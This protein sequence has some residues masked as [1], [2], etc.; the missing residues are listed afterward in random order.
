VPTLANLLLHMTVDRAAYTQQMRAAKQD[1]DDF[2]VGVTKSM[3]QAAAATESA[4]TRMSRAQRAQM[5]A[6]QAAVN[7]SG[8][9]NPSFAAAENAHNSAL[10]A[11]AALKQTQANVTATTTAVNGMNKS[12]GTTQY[13]IASFAVLGF[14]SFLTQSAHAAVD[15]QQSMLLL[16]TQ[17]RASTAEVRNMT[18]AVMQLAPALRTGPEELSKSLYHIESVGYRGSRALDIL[19]ISAQGARLGMSDIEDT[20]NA[21]VAAT[22]SGIEGID[23]M[24]EAMGTLD[25][26]VGTGNM[27]MEELVKSLRSGILST[28]KQ[29]GISLQDLTAALATMTDQGVPAAEAATRLRISIALLAAPTQTAARQLSRIGLT[30]TQIAEEMAGPRGLI[31]ALQLLRDHLTKSGLSAEQQSQLLVRAFGGG[32]TSS[33]I[34]LLINSL[35][36]MQQKLDVINTTATKFPELVQAQ[37]ETAAARFQELSAIVEVL[38]IQFGNV[39]LPVL[40]VVAN[41]IGMI[42]SQTGIMIP[43]LTTLTVI[44]VALATK[45]LVIF[46]AN[47]LKAG[48]AMVITATEAIANATGF[49]AMATASGAATISVSGLAAA[50]TALLAVLGP[51]A[52]A[53]AA[54]GAAYAIVSGNLD[55]QTQSLTDSTTKFANDQSRSIQELQTARDNIQKYLNELNKKDI[56]GGGFKLFGVWDV[57]GTEKKIQAQI[58]ILD[59]AIQNREAMLNGM[60]AAVGDQADEVLDQTKT[61]VELF[62]TS[63]EGVKDAAGAAGGAAMVEMAKEIRAHQNAPLDALTELHD[64]VRNQLTPTAEIA[65]L[66]GMLTAQDLVEG[67][68]SQDPAVYAQAVATQK[69]ITERLDELTNGAY[70]AGQNTT[71]NLAKGLS[72]ANAIGMLEAALKQIGGPIAAFLDSMSGST[73]FSNIL[74]QTVSRLQTAQDA[75]RALTNTWNSQF[76]PS[77]QAVADA[78]KGV[79]SELA[80][81]SRT[82]AAMSQLNSAFSQIQA[83]AHRFFDEVHRGNLKAIDDALK[84]K[85]ALLDIKKELNQA[86]VTA[87]QK[88][89]DFQRQQQEE[90]RLRLAVTQATDPQARHDA[91]VALQDFLQQKHINQMQ[92]EVD[93]A[94]DVID[95]QKAAN[96]A[97]AEAQKEAENQRYQDQV[98][99]FDR[100]LELLRRYLEKHPGEWQK[101]NERVLSLLKS[102]GIDYHNAGSLLGQNF[103]D[104]LKEQVAAAQA[105][106]Y[107]LADVIPGVNLPPPPAIGPGGAP[108]AY[109]PPPV[110]TNTGGGGNPYMTPLMPSSINTPTTNL[111]GAPG[112]YYPTSGDLILQVDGQELGRIV[113]F[114]L[115]DQTDANGRKRATISSSR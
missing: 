105:A 4:T 54:V 7:N 27:R 107:A 66:V 3:N 65:R 11:N 71:G 115:V 5:Q 6:L 45:H 44:I 47:L 2:A 35:G 108:G 98:E 100:Q 75:S 50:G 19:K 96:E 73:F 81:N 93:L 109:Y 25:A 86:P 49:T 69:L 39:L 18:E 63:L 13:L 15:F 85:N 29:F 42:A 20:T 77:A 58:D 38:G 31:G 51:L 92:A 33:G 68:K 87:A 95:Q 9:Q 56:S 99:S 17:A 10:A 40:I 14:I 78:M 114:N 67:L 110:T 91:I 52:I 37:A 103:V 83:S 97:Q 88:A 80:N 61:L 57:F 79:N 30:S 106:A 55:K 94:N 1:A 36:L 23:N 74:D 34:L 72:D 60:N 112:A 70:S 24:S 111:G 12:L 26:A 104:G 16:H 90:A 62:G 64:M 32:R 48:A 82:S 41:V 76:K 84:H 101:A 113:D 28:A 89:L 22:A 53:L 46:I 8:Y 59:A 21:L 102:Y 43:V